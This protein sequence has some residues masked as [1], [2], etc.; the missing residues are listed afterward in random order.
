MITIQNL[1]VHLEVE[2][3]GDEAAFIRM[4][5]KQINRWSRLAAEQ[6]MRQRQAD[7]DRSLG[8]R[9]PEEPGQC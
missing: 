8:D 3:D 6:K 9:L 2:G 5:D 7:G 1:E 4:F